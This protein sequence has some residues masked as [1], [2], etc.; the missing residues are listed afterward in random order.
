MPTVNKKRDNRFNIACFKV[1]VLNVVDL[2]LVVYFAIGFG[3][4]QQ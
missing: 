2:L 3:Y 1:Y 4:D